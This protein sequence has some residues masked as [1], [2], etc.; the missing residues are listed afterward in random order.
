MDLWKSKDSAAW[1]AVLDRYYDIVENIGK[2][3]LPEFE[4][5]V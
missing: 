5:L 4:R 2:D 3:K 1:E